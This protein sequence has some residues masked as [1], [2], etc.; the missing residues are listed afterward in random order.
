MRY[1]FA[2]ANGV[3]SLF[4][5][6]IREGIVQALLRALGAESRCAHFA[7]H[8]YFAVGAA[9]DVH[10]TG[11]VRQFQKNWAGHVV[12]AIESAANRRPAVATGEKNNGR[13]EYER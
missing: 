9:R 13:K 12:V 8:V 5:R 11:G 10:V 7:V 1:F 2:D 6:G 3:A 4:D